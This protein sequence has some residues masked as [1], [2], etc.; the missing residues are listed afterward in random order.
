MTRSMHPE[1]P[2][3]SV[4][5]STVSG[6]VSGT[7]SWGHK[8]AAIRL[9][10]RASKVSVSSL[11]SGSNRP[12][13]LDVDRHR[14]CAFESR[15]VFLWRTGSDGLPCAATL[16]PFHRLHHGDICNSLSFPSFSQ[17]TGT[18]FAVG[19]I[20]NCEVASDGGIFTFGHAHFYE[21]TGALTFNK[22]IVGMGAG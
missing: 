3:A 18:V 4:A 15:Q 16:Q 7:S 14:F 19:D 10:R 8:G 9:V 13:I 21:S 6:T 12:A 1:N 22:P 17:L 11:T 20:G 2:V 5:C